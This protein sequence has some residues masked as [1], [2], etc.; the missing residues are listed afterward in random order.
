M[1]ETKIITTEER[2]QYVRMDGE[3]YEID[4]VFEVA[5][6]MQNYERGNLYL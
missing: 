5:M 3:Y 1:A 6:S 2:P 4:V